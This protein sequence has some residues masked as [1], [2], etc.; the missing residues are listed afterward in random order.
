MVMTGYSV[1]RPAWATTVGS[2][3]W[4]MTTVR[5]RLP[6]SLGRREIC[7][8]S[9]GSGGGGMAAAAAAAA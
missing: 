5:P 9:G 6:F 8:G 2:L 1:T 4:V 3:P 7:A